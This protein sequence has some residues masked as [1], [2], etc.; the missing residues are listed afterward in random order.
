MEG[1]AVTINKRLE[2]AMIVFPKA[3]METSCIEL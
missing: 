2:P 1:F 3:L